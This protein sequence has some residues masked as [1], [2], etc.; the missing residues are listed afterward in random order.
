M[1]GASSPKRPRYSLTALYCRRPTI[2]GKE[3][4]NAL[5]LPFG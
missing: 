2:G 5:P 3:I 4:L 1:L